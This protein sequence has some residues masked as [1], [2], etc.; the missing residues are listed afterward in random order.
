MNQIITTDA[1]LSIPQARR[2]SYPS[3]TEIAAM[4]KLFTSCGHDQSS[5]ESVACRRYSAMTHDQSL[6]IHCWTTV[7]TLLIRIGRSV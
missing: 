5:S 1:R 6:L 7:K 4:A 3:H 2:E